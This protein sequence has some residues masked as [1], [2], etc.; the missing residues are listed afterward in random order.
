[1]KGL[2]DTEY[3]ASM[4]NLGLLEGE[5]KELEYLIEK[6]VIGR[7][8]GSQLKY[9]FQGFINGSIDSSK[10]TTLKK[11][12]LVFTNIN[13]IFIQQEDYSRSVVPL[14]QLGGMGCFTYNNHYAI[15]VVTVDGYEYGFDLC[16]TEGPSVVQNQKNEN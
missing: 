6:V 5:K 12:L 15:G 3:R 11:G 16:R 8:D 9:L 7:G 10:T 2:K 4:D 1:M 14:D 13:L